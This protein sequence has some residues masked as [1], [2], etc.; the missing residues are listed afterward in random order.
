MK[1]RGI[2]IFVAILYL[3]FFTL[4]SVIAKDKVRIGGNVVV[5]EGAE[6]K[7]AVAVGSGDKKV[8]N[9]PTL[10]QELLDLKMVGDEGAISDQ[11]YN[12]MKEKLKKSD[13]NQNN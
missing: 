3:V 6:V 10:G 9:Q 11:E 2:N 8:E 13:T 4:G 5:D 12:E 1:M 7:N